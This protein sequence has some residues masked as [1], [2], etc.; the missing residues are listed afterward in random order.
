MKAKLVSV[1]VVLM[2]LVLPTFPIALLPNARAAG[3]NE[4]A[5]ADLLDINTA[6]AEE[7]KALPRIGDAY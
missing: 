5:E 2:L 7:L 3:K 1:L 4:A 6:T